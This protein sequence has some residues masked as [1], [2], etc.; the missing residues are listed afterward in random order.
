[1]FYLA[2]L[3]DKQP[4]ERITMSLTHGLHEKRAQKGKSPN[5]QGECLITED[6]RGNTLA[7]VHIREQKNEI[8]K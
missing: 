2:R 6:R 7:N 4:N 5:E 1:M 3:G 8:V